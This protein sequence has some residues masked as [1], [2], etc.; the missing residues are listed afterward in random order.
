[1]ITSILS[2]F[3]KVVLNPKDKNYTGTLNGL[4]RELKNKG[5][6]F[7]FFDYFEL[8][9]QLLDL[10]IQLK[11]KYTVNLFTTGSIQN[12]PEIKERVN[13]VFEHIFSAEELGLDKKSTNSYKVIAEKIKTPTNQIL[14][15]D[16]QPENV[17][18]AKKAGMETLLYEDYQKLYDKVAVY[19]AKL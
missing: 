1:M 2:D 13:S 5:I 10:Y 16:D 4:Y 19:F 17:D 6:S 9:N 3:S 12:A 11:S 18:A 8:N 7:D 15:I 14:Y